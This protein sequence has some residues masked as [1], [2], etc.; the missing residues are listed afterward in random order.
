MRFPGHPLF[1]TADYLSDQ[2]ELSAHPTLSAF[3][4]DKTPSGARDDFIAALQFLQDHADSPGT[5]N[6]FRGEIQRLLLYL[7]L[8][9]GRTLST[10]N[11]ETLEHYYKFLRK[12]PRPWI[13]SQSHRG[14][15]DH[16]GHRV[17][18]PGWRPFIQRDSDKAYVAK[19]STIDAATR[20]L[21]AFF[22]HLE[23]RG[24]VQ[25]NP[26]L[27]VRRSSQKAAAIKDRN[28]GKNQQARGRARRLTAWQWACLLE[29]LL[30]A[31]ADN[32]RYERHLFIVVTLKSL[33]LRVGE[34]APRQDDSGVMR[35]PVFGDFGHEIIEG[36]R[37]WDLYVFGKG[38][39]HRC[40]TVP[41]AYLSYLQRWRRHLNLTPLPDSNEQTPILPKSNGD[42]LGERQVIRMVE[43]AF[44]LGAT[45]MRNN[46]Y[47][48]E[49]DQMAALNARTHYLRHTGA[50]MD[51]EAGRPIR[52]VSEDLGH[53]SV[54][55]T[56]QEYINS[57]HT[58]KYQSGRARA[59]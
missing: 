35:A 57:D 21:S 19:Q 15:Y 6:R 5:F 48:Q 10:T 8:V 2:Q 27:Q 44:Q 37:S 58:L 7:W 29:A 24:I 41:D 1:D 32:P 25:P 22:R 47:F 39:K 56:E 52:H 36:E 18:N 31:A 50:S 30:S 20:A 13:A 9:A 16:G 28:T 59:I 33:Y 23:I 40:V 26:F 11:P 46:G 49:A 34:L 51:I 45:Y 42:A 54:A 43:D 4:H 53:A 38:D 14:F 12:P 3:I 17:A 55:F